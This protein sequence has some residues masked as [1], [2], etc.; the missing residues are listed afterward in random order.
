MTHTS[1]VRPAA[2][3]HF[4]PSRRRR[5]CRRTRR[6]DLSIVMRLPAV[7]AFLLVDASEGLLLHSPSLRSDSKHPRDASCPLQGSS[8]AG[9]RRRS[10]RECL[11]LRCCQAVDGHDD[12]TSR[13]TCIHTLLIDNY[14]SYTYNLF[15]QLAVI[16]GRAPFVVYNDDDDGDLWW[17]FLCL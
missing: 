9:K 17:V 16:N 11:L 8:L 10:R 5:R 15:Q 12:A 4:F 7:L 14:D 6:V 2:K 13:S 3:R 1:A